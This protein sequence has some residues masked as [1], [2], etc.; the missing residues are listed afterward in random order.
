MIEIILFVILGFVLGL[1]A[2]AQYKTYN[3]NGEWNEATTY[4]KQWNPLNKPKLQAFTKSE[5]K[6]AS[7]P[8]R[9]D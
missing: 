8:A 1:I 6:K 7:N 5:I 4:W 9:H 2:T 3:A